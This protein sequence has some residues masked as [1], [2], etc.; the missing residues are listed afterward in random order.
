MSRRKRLWSVELLNEI[1]CNFEHLFLMENGSDGRVTA[2]KEGRPQGE[3]ATAAVD[4]WESEA[5]E[6]AE[7]CYV[8]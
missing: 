3:T 7:G 6:R 1:F 2:I 5:V 4:G 8:G